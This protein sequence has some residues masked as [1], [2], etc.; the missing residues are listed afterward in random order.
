MNKNDEIKTMNAS[1]MLQALIMLLT[2]AKL[3]SA[4]EWLKNTWKNTQ[5]LNFDASLEEQGKNLYVGDGGTKKT[6]ATLIRYLANTFGAYVGKTFYAVKSGGGFNA[7]LAKST[8][9]A[10]LHHIGLTDE[11]GTILDGAN[12]GATVDKIV[13]D[14][15]PAFIAPIEEKKATSTE[16]G[17]GSSNDDDDDDEDDDDFSDVVSASDKVVSFNAISAGAKADY[18]LA[19]LFMSFFEMIKTCGSPFGTVLNFATVIGN[20]GLL[21]WRRGTFTEALANGDKTYQNGAGNTKDI[22][23]IS[24]ASKSKKI[25]NMAKHD[26]SYT[27]VLPYLLRS[28]GFNF[29][30]RKNLFAHMKDTYMDKNAKQGYQ[31]VCASMRLIMNAIDNGAPAD[32]VGSGFRQ[33]LDADDIYAIVDAYTVDGD[34]YPIVQGSSGDGRGKV[35]D[36][37]FDEVLN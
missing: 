27:F 19:T 21:S 34:F 6:G 32:E 11:Q 23:C 36:T 22:R 35:V 37:S 10:I 30:G 1:A 3:T 15:S 26:F 28:M 20:K 14:F 7:N 4:V 13:L 31:F 24:H 29:N 18:P 16:F 2:A 33:Y 8:A 12:F 25:D 9:I 17:Q 5:G